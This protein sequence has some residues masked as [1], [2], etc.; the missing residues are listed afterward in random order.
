PEDDDPI[1]V[2]VARA[3]DANAPPPEM[4]PPPV[5]PALERAMMGHVPPAPP[6]G[7]P[8]IPTWAA[9]VPRRRWP[10]TAGAALALAAVVAL[11]G[12][13]RPRKSSRAPAQPPAAAVAPAAAPIAQKPESPAS[14]PEAPPSEPSRPSKLAQYAASPWAKNFDRA[15]KALW[16]NRPGG[17]ETILPDILNKPGLSRRDRARAARMMGEAEA[18]KGNRVKATRWWRQAFQ[19]YDDPEER[20]RVARLIQ[21]DKRLSAR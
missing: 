13:R 20:A 5:D 18:K 9:S 19:L 7:A 14:S 16:T 1:A 8:G 10:A 15:Q 17:A 2:P 3:P 12:A 4:L 6:E 21:G 11:L